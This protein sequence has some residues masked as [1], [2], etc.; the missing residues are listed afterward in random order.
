M[1]KKIYVRGPVLSQSGYGEQSRFALRALRSREDILDIFIQPTSWGQTGWVWS[2]DDF[3]Q[4]MDERIT[5]TQVLIHKKQFS[6]D[7]S[8][9]I[10]IPNE[11]QKIA[12]E[13]YG[14]TAGIETTKV[15][16][17]W[18]VKG[19][20]AVEKILVVSNHAKNTYVNT[21]TTVKNSE[22]NETIE[23]YKLET[24]VEVVWESTER[25]EP[26]NIPGLDLTTDFN[27]LIVSQMGP[28]KNFHSAITWWVEEFFDQEMGLLVKTNIRNNSHMDLEATQSQLSQIL[29]K[30]PE[31]KCKIYL[32]H[33]DLTPGQMTG[34]Y[35]NE[36]I[37]AMINI[38]HGE[39]FGLPL[40]EAAREGLP[41]ITINWGGQ[42]DFLSR[43][44]E[45]YFQKVDFSVAPIQGHAV[46]NGVL[47][48]D[49]EWAYADQGSYKM[50]LRKTYKSYNKALE[51]AQK[52][53]ANIEENFNEEKLYAGFCKHF[54]DK[55]DDS[56]WWNEDEEIVEY[57]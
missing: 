15:A 20:E 42:T 22:T 55:F 2:D 41:V 46:W 49:S 8:L 57:E 47:E 18:L 53:K 29:S 3:R 37:K 24:P 31:R 34:L 26:E 23:N 39:G 13:N 36:K 38:A 5:L 28:R 44:G 43:N 14:Y 51:K 25:H 19:N 12:P 52:A 32:L 50:Q 56:D 45:K 6:P 16:P 7:I 35:T 54:I 30:Y 9:Q 17:D 33:G 40:F 21:T 27:F 48:A 10:T 1:K 4:W 11:F